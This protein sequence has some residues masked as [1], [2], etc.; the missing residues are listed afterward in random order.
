MARYQEKAIK[1]I[2]K[3]IKKL[4]IASNHLIIWSILNQITKLNFILIKNSRDRFES[5]FNSFRKPIS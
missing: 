4:N 3:L 5:K 2:K 1:L